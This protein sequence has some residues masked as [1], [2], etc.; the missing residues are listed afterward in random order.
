MHEDELAEMSS[1]NLVESL[2]NKY[3]QQLG[4]RDSKILV[5]TVDEFVCLFMLCIAYYEYLKSDR[6]RTGPTNKELKVK[7]GQKSVERT[8]NSKLLREALM[9]M[10]ETNKF[11]T[12]TLHIDIEEVFL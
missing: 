7:V 11:C 6:A 5:A 8:S 12:R 9:K 4:N 10:P 1:C 2:H 3:K